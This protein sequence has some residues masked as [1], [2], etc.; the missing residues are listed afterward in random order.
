M[1]NERKWINS[2]SARL[3]IVYAITAVIIICAVSIASKYNSVL[4]LIF[5]IAGIALVVWVSSYFGKKIGREIKEIGDRIDELA[6]GDLHTRRELHEEKDEFDGLYNNLENTVERISDTMNQL[7]NGLDQLAAGNLNFALPDDLPG[8]IG[9]LAKKYNQITADLRATFKDIDAASGQVTSG[10]EQVASGAQTLSQGATE[11]AASIEELTAQ[12]EDI[13]K[14]VNSTAAAAKSTTMIVKE[15]GDRIAECSKEM[16]SML[17][18]MDDINKS[19][20]EISKIIKVIDDIAFQTNILA[21]NAA[22]EAARAG[23]AGKGFA[24]V[25][26]EVRN[27]AAKSAEAANQTTA[28]IEGSVSNVEKGSKIA[29]ETAKVLE[30]IVDNAAKIDSEV[31]KISA[32]SEFQADEIKRVTVGVEQISSVVQSNTA[33][34]EESAAASE[35]LSGQSGI[36]KR[37]LSHF[38]FEASGSRSDAAD[39]YTYE[40]DDYSSG[41]VHSSE[42]MNISF[43]SEAF[44]EPAPEAEMKMPHE[45]EDFVPVDFSSGNFASASSRKPDHIYLDDDFENVNSK[46]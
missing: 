11:Q 18:S 7:I 35:E 21:L 20:A 31:S 16:D 12:I 27:L 15:T 17:A 43:D 42:D 45:D 28:L 14:Q 24:V 1:K 46:Y 9:D 40:S 36:L 30:T 6:A 29:K 13:S 4:Q 41:D 22:V 38:K 37:L 34:A 2:L 32:A 44:T 19:S 10:S 39:S 33:T 5:T 8:D 3:A 26:D 25:A 23:A